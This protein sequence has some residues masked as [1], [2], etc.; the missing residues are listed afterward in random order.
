MGKW[1][2]TKEML[3]DVSDWL[4]G[5]GRQLTTGI[6]SPA[7]SWNIMAKMLHPHGLVVKGSYDGQ[8]EG[9]GRCPEGQGDLNWLVEVTASHSSSGRWHS[10]SGNPLL[11]LLSFM[12]ISSDMHV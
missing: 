1:L 2:K 11:S 9:A 4:N 5:L 12:Y 6:V 10:G 3:L 8:A 7:T